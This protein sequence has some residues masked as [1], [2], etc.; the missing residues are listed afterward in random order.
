LL[1][2]ASKGFRFEKCGTNSEFCVMLVPVYVFLPKKTVYVVT[3]RKK[4]ATFFCAVSLRRPHK[5]RSVLSQKKRCDLFVVTTR[6]VVFLFCGVRSIAAAACVRKPWLQAQVGSRPAQTSSAPSSTNPF[7]A[8]TP[9]CGSR[10]TATAAWP[11][12]S[13]PR[14][15]TRRRW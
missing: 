14:P 4:T 13:G 3:K 10:A 7:A 9:S 6:A 12:S 5:L 1:S 15:T 8:R 11:A 2:I